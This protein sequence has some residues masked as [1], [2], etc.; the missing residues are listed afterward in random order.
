MSSVIPFARLR[1]TKDDRTHRPGECTHHHIK[2]D[3]RGGIVNCRECGA[4]LTPFWALMMLADQYSVA[5]AQIQRLNERVS[6]ADARILELS[7]ELDARTDAERTGKASPP[8][9]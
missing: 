2:L 6:Q 4:A 8:R 9:P 1:V 7:G 5:L 3:T